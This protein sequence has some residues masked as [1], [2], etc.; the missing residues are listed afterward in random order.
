MSQPPRQMRPSTSQD[1]RF[2]DASTIPVISE[3]ST[4][5]QGPCPPHANFI[6]YEL[7]GL[8]EKVVHGD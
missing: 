7:K 5:V 2:I 4:N 6:S 3:V 1:V 8:K